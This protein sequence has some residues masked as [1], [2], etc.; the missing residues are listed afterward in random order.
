M[1]ISMKTLD[2]ID[3]EHIDDQKYLAYF[4][5]IIKLFIRKTEDEAEG[6]VSHLLNDMH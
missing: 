1:S 6:N 4:K 3:R 5:G 2:K